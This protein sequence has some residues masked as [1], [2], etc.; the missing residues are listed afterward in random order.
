MKLKLFN[1]IAGLFVGINFVDAAAMGSPSAAAEQVVFSD[2]AW[3]GIPDPGT[4]TKNDVM[5]LFVGEIEKDGRAWSLC[6][7]NNDS[8]RAVTE[9]QNFD[10]EQLEE[11]GLFAHKKFSVDSEGY[12][13][14]ELMLVSQTKTDIDEDGNEFM[15]TAVLRIGTQLTSAELAD[16][17]VKAV[18]SPM[19]FELQSRL[20]RENP[21]EYERT[22]GADEV[23]K[24]LIFIKP[25]M[26]ATLAAAIE[27]EIGGSAAAADKK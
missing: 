26:R 14:Y 25:E 19:S 17:I 8:L 24:M 9:D 1:V 11:Q 16:P 13:R 23:R 12:I 6:S 5:D 10:I 18:R 4:L 2:E 22:V 27:A 7:F 15:L 20:H 21:A 3:A